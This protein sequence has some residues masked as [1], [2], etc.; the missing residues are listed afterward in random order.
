MRTWRSC[1]SRSPILCSSFDPEGRVQWGNHAAERLFNRSLH[2]SIGFSGIELVHPD[3]L[4]LAPRSLTSV[5]HKEVGT[6]I[7]VRAKAAKGWVL[8]GSARRPRQLAR[9]TRCAL[10]PARS[11]RTAP[12]RGRPRR[13]GEVPVSSAQFGH[14]DHPCLTKTGRVD[15]V[16]GALT[17]MLRATILRGRSRSRS[18]TSFSRPTDPPSRPRWNLLHGA[19]P[20]PTR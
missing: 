7:E 18:P 12:L 6:L 20:H 2:D 13:G 5:Q 14:D 17:R 4:E 19:R 9:Q 1:S 8:L 15:S 16:S 10:L 3:D 11:D